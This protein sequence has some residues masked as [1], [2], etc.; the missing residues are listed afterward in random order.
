[1]ISRRIVRQ[2]FLFG[3]SGVAGYLADS[4]IT[5]FLKPVLGL[6]ASRIPAFAI[7]ATVTWLIN[8]NITFRDKKSRHDKLW[9]E[10][11]HYL[12]LMMLGAVVNYVV[13]AV[14]ITFLKDLN[15]AVFICVGI[16]SLVGMIVNY[17]T[18]NRFI[19]NQTR[20]S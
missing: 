19:Y 15:Y 10:Y 14:S 16:G 1:M 5:F 12:S 8:R 7:A 17:L 18:S 4:S 3:I 11:T 20:D 6:Y 2:L 9:K 13:Y